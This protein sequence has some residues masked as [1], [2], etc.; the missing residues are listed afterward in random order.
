[1]RLIRGAALAAMLVLWSSGAA[2]TAAIPSPSA[3]S[4]LR[5]VFCAKASSCWAVGSY[6]APGGGGFNQALRFNGKHW[7]QA[8]VPQAGGMQTSDNNS[9]SAISCPAT[10]DCWAVGFY[11]K[12]GANN[13]VLHWNGKRWSSVEVPEPGSH[14][15][16]AINNLDAISCTSRS[17]CWAVGVFTGKSKGFLNQTLHWNGRNWSHVSAP[18]PGGTESSAFN[19]LEGVSCVSPSNCW[20]AGDMETT[21]YF[22]VVLHWNGKKWSRT[23]TPQPGGSSGSNL[24]SIS[25]GSTSMCVAVG[26]SNTSGGASLN[27]VLRFNGKKWTRATTPQPGHTTLNDQN[28]L[29]GVSCTS[30]ASC[31]ALGYFA[32]GLSA[33]NLSEALRFNGKKW[34]RIKTP[35]PGGTDVGNA[36]EPEGVWCASASDCTA[37]GVVSSGSA[38]L[39]LALRWNGKSWTNN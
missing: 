18:N 5:G 28:Q 19:I 14:G 23:K 27:Q 12:G 39:N 24:E 10:S 4:L 2:A 22:N 7:T 36:T 37:V 33:P 3:N 21:A 30:K 6:Q 34:T 1:M 8:K 20:A 35:Q 17:S 9:L 13:E 11:N 29:T 38:L 26:Y 15:S 16:G 32:S 25:C 31:W